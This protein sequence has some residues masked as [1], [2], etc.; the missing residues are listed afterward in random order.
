[1]KGEARAGKLFSA[2]LS[3]TPNSEIGKTGICLKYKIS[4]ERRMMIM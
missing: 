2:P 4:Y 1:M 3:I